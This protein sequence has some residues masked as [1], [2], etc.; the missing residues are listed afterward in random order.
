MRVEYINPFVESVAEFFSTMLGS[1]VERMNIVRSNPNV[2]GNQIRALIG[3]SGAVCGSVMLVL[4]PNTGSNMIQ[5]FLSM[6]TEPDEETLRDG[7][8]EAVNIIAGNAKARLPQLPEHTIS[9]SLP[10]VIRGTGVTI[11]SPT[12]AV[13]IEI[14]FKSDLGVFSLRVAFIAIA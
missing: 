2:E 13:W 4:E 12:N 7:V 1:K 10:T 8:A 14:P 3:M 11:D 6:T 9:L 5:R